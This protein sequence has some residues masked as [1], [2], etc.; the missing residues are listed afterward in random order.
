[1]RFTV[2]RSGVMNS[3]QQRF[4]QNYALLWLATSILAART[5]VRTSFVPF[6]QMVARPVITKPYCRHHMRTVQVCQRLAVL[7]AIPRPW[8]RA[9]ASPRGGSLPRR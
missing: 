6:L 7:R 5:A 4:S 3:D 2:E 1:A 8:F 9:A